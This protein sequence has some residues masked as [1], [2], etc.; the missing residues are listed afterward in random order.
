MGEIFKCKCKKNNSN[1]QIIIQKYKFAK[2]NAC[3]CLRFTFV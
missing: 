2:L 1:M 3:L